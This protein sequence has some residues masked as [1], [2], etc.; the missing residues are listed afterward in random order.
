VDRE[1]LKWDAEIRDSSDDDCGYSREVLDGNESIN[2]SLL[3]GE[4]LSEEEGEREEEEGVEVDAEEKCPDE[5]KKE[6]DEIIRR[7]NI[8]DMMMVT[9]MMVTDKI[10]Y[11]LFLLEKRQVRWR[12]GWR[13]LS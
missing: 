5:W 10:I 2:L 7:G 3:P 11:I 9:D 8:T 6:D 1:K 4:D 13:R 12:G